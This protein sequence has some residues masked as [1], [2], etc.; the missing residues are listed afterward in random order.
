[1]AKLGKE[2]SSKPWKVIN[3]G[4]SNHMSGPNH[5]GKQVSLDSPAGTTAGGA[6][7]S[8]G[9]FGKGGP[10]TGP[11]HMVSGQQHAGP[12][13]PGQS[14]AGGL[15]KGGGGFGGGGIKGGTTKMFGPQKAAP[16]QPR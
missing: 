8:G 11:G 9:G 13:T 15:S 6:K 4:T 2:I 5:A 14:A 12:Q 7:N 10:Q 1:M 16:A 3:E